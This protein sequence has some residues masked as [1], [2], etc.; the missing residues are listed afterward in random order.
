MNY[1]RSSV[2]EF[3][4]VDFAMSTDSGAQMKAIAKR[5][6]IAHYRVLGL[7]GAG[8]MGAVYKAHDEKLD[9]V[10]ALKL[11]AAE[12]LPSED[13]RRRFL[14]EAR[15]A[16]ALNHPNILTI[17]DIGEADGKPFIAMEFIQGETLRSRISKKSLS[18]HNALDIATQV[19]EGLSKAHEHGIVHRDLKPENLMISRDGFAK[20]LDFG[21]AK[22]VGRERSAHVDSTEKTVMHVNTQAGTIMGTI[23]YMSP[24]QIL[25]RKV[26]QRSDV[27]SF[28]I[29]L[30]EMATGQRPFSGQNDIDTMHAILHE[31]PRPPHVISNDLPRDLHRIITK[32]LAKQPKER[33]QAIRE[34]CDEIK[35]LRRSLETGRARAPAR[36]KL[37][38]KSVAATA[39]RAIKV[40][41]ANSLNEA[42]YQAVTTLEGPL[43]IVAGAGTGKTRTLVYRL[44]RLIEM[45]VKP[46]SVLLLTFTRR[47][48]ASMLAR[49]AALA[50]ERCQR[51]SGGTF[52]SLAYGVLRKHSELAGIARSFTVLDQGDNEDLIDLLKRQM[53]FSGKERHFP[54]KRTIG[55][56]FSMSVNKVIPITEV[57]EREYP[58]YLDE[59]ADLQKL[60]VEFEQYKRHRHLVSYDDLLVRLRDALESSAE[61]REKLSSQYRYLMVDEYQDTNRLQ[62]QIIRLIASSHDNVAVVGDECQSIYSFRGA[63][64]H[65]MIEFPGLFPE[66]KVIKLEENF[67]STQPVLDLANALIAEAKEGYAK[68]LFSQTGEGPAPMLISTSDENE[69]SR[70][71]AQRIEELHEDGI[72]FSE[73]AVLFRASSHSFD[74][75]IELAKHGIPFRKFGGIKFAESAHIKDLLA[76]LRV[77]TNP[78]DTLSW[79]RTLKLVDNVGDVTVEQIL[80][81]LSVEEKE[82]RTARAKNALFKKLKQ[83]PGKASYKDQLIRFAHLLTTVVEQKTPRSQL[84]TA[85]RYYRPILKARH[86][87]H[88]RRQRELEHLLTIAK[89]YKSGDELLADVALDPVD[90]ALAEAAARGDGYVTLSTVHS[91]KGLEWNALFVIWMMDGWFPSLRASDV[92]EDLEEETR[93]LYV[94]ATRAKEHLYFTCPMSAHEGYGSNFTPGISRF[95]E[96]LPPNILARATLLADGEE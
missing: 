47:A 25:G 14:Q 16:S 91:A 79:R 48:A 82:F 10:V 20:I 53:G 12:A 35:E 74:L 55:A 40:D 56:I 13:R 24:E 36:T 45:G 73:I 41:Y 81:Y 34:L 93:L 43:L 26:D 61:L 68:R 42:Q 5:A 76:F 33:Y 18:F 94:A 80:Q 86:D 49:A 59:Q 89:R 69:Q 87:D 15:A 37:V 44:A 54:R 23:H 2:V 11:L 57:L 65:N 22:L 8:G 72:P 6:K 32:A 95:L 30:Y 50:D 9:R 28:G 75:E 84:A 38:I 27:F 83:F 7:L 60:S 66:A 1:N 92:F 67:R 78:S 63:S 62:A 21:L 31:E 77:V 90:L 29:V 51:V 85:E 3:W 70:F 58:Q 96:N 71:V 52:H 64:F 46:E 88:P 39:Q 4:A 19:A 17:Y